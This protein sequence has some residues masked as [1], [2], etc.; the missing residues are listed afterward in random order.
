MRVWLW[1]AVIAACGS[2][3]AVTPTAS[4]LP[5][6]AAAGPV[7]ASN[8]LRGDYAGS[9]ACADCHAAIYA[10]WEGSAMRGM[11]RDA[12]TAAIR[13]PFDGATLQVGD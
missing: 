1:L 7:V 8:I 11:T 6:Q 10:A 5:P 3:R 13:A 2:P 9:A 12:D 4:A